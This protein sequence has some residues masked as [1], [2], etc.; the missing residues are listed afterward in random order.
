MLYEID[1]MKIH[2]CQFFQGGCSGLLFVN[3]CIQVLFYVLPFLDNCSILSSEILYKSL[4]HTL[5]IT[6]IKK[7]LCF[8]I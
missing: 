3:F 2:T 7:L 6:R 8:A 1:T 4:I 5:T